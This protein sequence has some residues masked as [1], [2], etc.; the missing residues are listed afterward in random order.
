MGNGQATSDQ[1]TL[2][3]IEPADVEDSD[4]PLDPAL[5]RL[6]AGLN[7]K[8]LRTLSIPFFLSSQVHFQNP[9]LVHTKRHLQYHMHQ[10]L[11]SR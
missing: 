10:R 4:P 9:Y 7:H 3:G 5:Y 1:M 8:F 11:L 6:I 2:A